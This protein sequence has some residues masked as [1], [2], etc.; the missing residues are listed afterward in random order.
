LIVPDRAQGAQNDLDFADIGDAGGKGDLGGAIGSTCRQACYCAQECV[1]HCRWG[2]A[3]QLPAAGSISIRRGHLA[4]PCFAI[5][6]DREISGMAVN[7]NA[8]G[9]PHGRRFAFWR[10]GGFYCDLGA[11]RCH[12]H[13]RRGGDPGRSTDVNDIKE[14]PLD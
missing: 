1:L 9:A 6:V 8:N 13:D 10:L 3:G 2:P 4:S 14:A 5:P 7:E 11:R 12:F